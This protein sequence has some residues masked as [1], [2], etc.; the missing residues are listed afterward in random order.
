VAGAGGYAKKASR[1]HNL[2]TS[3]GKTPLPT[4]T[5]TVRED[6]VF[7]AFNQDDSGF[8]RITID[9]HTLVGEYF[10]VPFD[11]GPVRR[12]DG[13]TLDWHRHKIGHD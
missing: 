3:P 13:V 4:H 9:K 11:G 5:A 10:A 12:D 2:Q 7:E 1:L 6:V 8:L